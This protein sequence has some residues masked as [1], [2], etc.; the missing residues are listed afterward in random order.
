MHLSLRRVWCLAAAACLAVSDGLVV[1]PKPPSLASLAASGAASAELA[2]A[3]DEDGS[4]SDGIDPFVSVYDLG[5]DPIF[6][7]Q[8]RLALVQSLITSVRAPP[9]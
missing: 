5:R 4:R 8:D 2:F 9:Q 7:H 3:T 6:F 1:V